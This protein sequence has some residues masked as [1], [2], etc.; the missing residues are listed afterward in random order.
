[1]QSSVDGANSGATGWLTL[2]DLNVDASAKS[3]MPGWLTLDDLNVN[4][5]AKPGTPG[6]LTLDDLTV[7]SDD[8]K[9]APVPTADKPVEVMQQANGGFPNFPEQPQQSKLRI[10]TRMP[11]K[12]R[13]K[14]SKSARL[15]AK[16]HT[17]GLIQKHLKKT[18]NHSGWT[19]LVLRAT[20]LKS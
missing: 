2:D 5:S 4:A 20:V 11:S 12:H 17:T 3:S 16:L 10:A 19:P 13:Q 7:D 18:S 6:W 15:N 9:T 14:Y 8:S 1:M